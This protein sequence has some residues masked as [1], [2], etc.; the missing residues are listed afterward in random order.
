MDFL[1]IKQANPGCLGGFVF[2]TFQ[3]SHQFSQTPN[4]ICEA[5]FH[6]R[7]DAKCLMHPAKV[8]DTPITMA[9]E[10]KTATYPFFRKQSEVEGPSKLITAGR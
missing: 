1:Q 8:V 6:R 9:A 10:F 5:S 2:L 3:Y 7:R 4:M